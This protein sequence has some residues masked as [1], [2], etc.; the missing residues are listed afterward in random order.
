MINTWGTSRRR[1]SRVGGQAVDNRREGIQGE[2]YEVD[3]A[4][5]EFAEQAAAARNE[6]PASWFGEVRRDEMSHEDG[7]RDAPQQLGPAG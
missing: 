1:L 3:T 2:S 6:A 7:S 4:G 5:R